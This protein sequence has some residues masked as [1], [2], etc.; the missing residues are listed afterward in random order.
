M[1]GAW[2]WVHV[3]KEP[4]FFMHNTIKDIPCAIDTNLFR[5]Q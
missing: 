1:M 2:N 5:I 3:D 4:N